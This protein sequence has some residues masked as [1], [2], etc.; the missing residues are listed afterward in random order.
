[1]LVLISVKLRLY[2]EHADFDAEIKFSKFI[3]PT[4]KA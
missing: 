3:S 2:R 1:M 4:F